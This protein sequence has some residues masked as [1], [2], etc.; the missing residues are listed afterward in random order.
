MLPLIGNS[1]EYHHHHTCTLPDF[2][3]ILF[4]DTA[5]CRKYCLNF[6]ICR[7]ESRQNTTINRQN[8]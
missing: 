7:F 5:I 1:S 6:G 8:A 3:Q 2:K 4:G